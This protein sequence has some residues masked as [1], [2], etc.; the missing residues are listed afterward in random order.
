MRHTPGFE[1]VRWLLGPLMPLVTK[2][3]WEGA[4][5]TL[6]CATAPESELHNGGYYKD[7]AEVPSPNALTRDDAACERLW[8]LSDEA[9]HQALLRRQ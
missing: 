3:P 8:A 2:T 9:V 4:Q 1:Y 6:Y 7:C 5:T